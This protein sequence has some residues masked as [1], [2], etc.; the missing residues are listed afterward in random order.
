MLEKSV[1]ETCWRELLEKS[2][3]EEVVEKFCREEVL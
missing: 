2:V 3:V 1:A